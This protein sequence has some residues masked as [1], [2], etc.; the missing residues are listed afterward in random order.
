MLYE[1]KDIALIFVGH[2]AE[3]AES[4]RQELKERGLSCS[5][6]NA[7][8]VKP[9]DTEMIQQLREGHK[10][11]VTIEENVISGGFGA[12]VME[13]VSNERLGI[14]VY[15]IGLPDSFIEQGNIDVLR[16]QIGFEKSQLAD[17][18][19]EEFER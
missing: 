19:I 7:R 1:E 6:I 18:I 5:L 2:M 3:L 13:Y 4:I 17:R 16:K 11:I 14:H 9:L 15:N 12:R 10:L 8:F